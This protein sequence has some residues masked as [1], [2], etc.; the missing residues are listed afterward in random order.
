MEDLQTLPSTVEVVRI[1]HPNGRQPDVCRDGRGLLPKARTEIIDLS[2]RS[3][4]FRRWARVR[5]HYHTSLVLTS[6]SRW[7][8]I[9]DACAIRLEISPRT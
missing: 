6:S 1:V 7:S 2:L 8:L 4:P 5:R 9:A 3:N